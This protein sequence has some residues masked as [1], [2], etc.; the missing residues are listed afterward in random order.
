MA[1]T[2][3]EKIRR[4]NTDVN[5]R[6]SQQGVLVDDV[7]REK[8]GS[9]TVGNMVTT[10]ANETVPLLRRD[11]MVVDNP[12]GGSFD[13]INLEFTLSQPVAG[14]ANLVVGVVTQASGTVNFPTRTDFPAPGSGSFWWDG[15]Q[16]IRV[17]QGDITSAQDRVFAVYP[18]KE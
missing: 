14:A 16:I 18:R 17:G 6:A 10:L 5:A 8:R 2:I 1:D 7:R 11:R 3:R 12:V 15:N 9:R 13:G 4:Y